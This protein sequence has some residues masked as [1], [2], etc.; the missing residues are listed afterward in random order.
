MKVNADPHF[1]ASTVLGRYL[2][3]VLTAGKLALAGDADEEIGT[4]AVQAIVVDAPTAI[5]PKRWAGVRKMVVSEAVA[6]GDPLF[7][8]AGGK[9]AKAGTLAR[10]IVL[11]V[12]TADGAEINVLY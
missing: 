3:V 6:V 2:R 8:A 11:E 12:A 4:T 7:A 9:V 1:P 10:G 5:V